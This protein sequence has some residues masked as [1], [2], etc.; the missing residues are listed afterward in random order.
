MD[1][2]NRTLADLRPRWP[3]QEVPDPAA[4]SAAIAGDLAARL[5]AAIANNRQLIVI[6]PVGP[7]DYMAWA[8]KLNHEQLAGTALAIVNMDEYLDDATG[9]LVAWDHPLSFRRFMRDSFYGLLEGKAAVPPENQIFPD[10]HDPGRVTALLERHGGAD[11]CYAGIGLSGHVAFNDPPASRD[12]V[13]RVLDLSAV[14]RSQ[15][16]LAGTDGIWELIPRRA[17]TVGMREVLAARTLHFTLL[18][19]WHAG[20]WRRAF[21]GPL[22]AD[23]PASFAQEHPDLRITITSLAAAPPSMH[24]ALRI[25]K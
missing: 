16:C 18:R 17:V 10:P 4:L 22:S 12:C 20:L 6:A 7:L 23:F 24:A 21:F 5:R 19:S 14:T 1:F 3:V 25:G 2:Y 13:T 9:E 15:T 11:V 8:R